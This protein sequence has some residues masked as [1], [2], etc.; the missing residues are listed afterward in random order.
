MPLKMPT[1]SSG[2]VYIRLPDNANS[3][4]SRLAALFFLTMIF[5]MTP[6]SY[7][8]FYFSDRRFFL[9]DSANGLY[10]PSAYQMGT[11]T[12]GD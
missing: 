11:L 7:M 4:S 2:L 10:A 9:K 5:Q 12:A 1:F 6:F 3:S 8:T